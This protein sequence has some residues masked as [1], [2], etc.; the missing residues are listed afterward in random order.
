MKGRERLLMFFCFCFVDQRYLIF[1][2]CFFLVLFVSLQ[3]APFALKNSQ[4]ITV[5][6]DLGWSRAPIYG[7][8][9]PRKQSPN[10]RDRHL[11]FFESHN[12]NWAKLQ[13]QL[14]RRSTIKAR[15]AIQK[16]RRRRKSAA[17]ENK[18]TKKPKVLIQ[19][20]IPSVAFC[21]S[22]DDGNT[23][24]AFLLNCYPQSYNGN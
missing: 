15:T 9:F 2:F 12:S 13:S 5:Y 17:K 23:N 21:K 6:I 19:L 11:T 24:K 7:S 3:L 18:T 1:V 14:S 10:F 22:I 4:T 20:Q 8:N 16:K